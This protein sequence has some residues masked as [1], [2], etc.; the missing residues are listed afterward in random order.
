MHH[1]SGPSGIPYPDSE[2]R[3][4]RMKTAMVLDGILTPV[5]GKAAAPFLFSVFA[6]RIGGG[7]RL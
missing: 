3:G 1:K 4:A 2:G 6:S 7:P 5:A